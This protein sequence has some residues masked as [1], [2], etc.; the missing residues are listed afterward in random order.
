MLL[1]DD[2]WCMPDACGNACGTP[3]KVTPDVT[4]RDNHG[5][6]GRNAAFTDGHVEWINSPNV[7]PYFQQAQKD[8]DD[9]K[10]QNFETID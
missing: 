3:P 5:A 1:A 2:A 6:A 8:Y 7:D 4:S 9:M 10:D